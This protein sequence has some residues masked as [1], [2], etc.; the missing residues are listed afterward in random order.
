VVPLL[1]A[2]LAPALVIP[3]VIMLMFGGGVLGLHPMITGTVLL[4]SLNQLP[5]QVCDLA[6]MEAVLCG[7]ALASMTSI[8]SLSVVS[9]GALYQ[10]PPLQLAFSPNLWFAGTFLLF[11][12]LLL[13]LINVLLN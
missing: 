10:V 5:D 4:V 8:S 13:S 12:S 9:A 2:W 1:G 3:V 11:T 7:W 6:L